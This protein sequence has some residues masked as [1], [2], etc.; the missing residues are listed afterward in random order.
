MS[1]GIGAS[2]SIGCRVIG[3]GNVHAPG[4]ERLARDRGIRLVHRAASPT[5]GQPRDARCTRIWWVRPVTSSHRRSDRPFGRRVITSYRVSLGAPS[6]LTTTRRRSAASRPSGSAMCPRAGSGVPR[7][8]ATY[9]LRIRPAAASRCIAACTSG[10]SAMTTRPEVS[11]SRRVRMP[12]CASARSR[13]LHNTLFSSVPD[14]FLYV[15]C[16]TTPGGL[17]RTITHSSS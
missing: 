5:I 4:V 9:S 2:D 11:L 1:S 12:G 6:S 16:T 3:C 10:V 14:Q 17:S 7:T 8:T 13:T 15:G